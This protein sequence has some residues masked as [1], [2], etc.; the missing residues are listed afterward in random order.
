M[1][2]DTESINISKKHVCTLSCTSLMTTEVQK[3]N[4][5]DATTEI[6]KKEASTDYS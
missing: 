2:R 5:N 6:I 3:Y 1:K 4:E